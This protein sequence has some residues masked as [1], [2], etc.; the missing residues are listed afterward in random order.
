MIQQLFCCLCCHSCSSLLLSWLL[1]QAER[2][3]TGIMNF[4]NPGCIS[5]NEVSAAAGSR[6]LKLPAVLRVRIVGSAALP[7]PLP[8][9]IFTLFAVMDVS[10]LS[11]HT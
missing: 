10:Y 8:R 2:K 6:S 7:R 9:S 3:L 11:S 1:L 4:T 5:H